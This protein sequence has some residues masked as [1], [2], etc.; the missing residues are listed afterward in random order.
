M[1]FI[2]KR[3]KK[4]SVVYRVK[5]DNGTERQKSEGFNTL[6]K[7]EARKKEIE[8]KKSVGRFIIPKCTKLKELI[9][10]YVKI[11]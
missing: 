9:N 5:G 6:K 2:R 3:N 4:F 11:C 10:E 1:A 7:A 8:Y